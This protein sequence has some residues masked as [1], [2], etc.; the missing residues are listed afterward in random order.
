MSVQFLRASLYAQCKG[1]RFMSIA[2][3]VFLYSKDKQHTQDRWQIANHILFSCWLLYCRNTHKY[4]F[5]S[6]LLLANIDGDIPQGI[7]DLAH[8]CGD[9]RAFGACLHGISE[10]GLWRLKHWALAMAPAFFAAGYS[11]TL[12]PATARKGHRCPV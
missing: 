6:H 11:F 5:P 8:S 4:C 10:A 9:K 7:A 1:R 12:L 3:S 2:S